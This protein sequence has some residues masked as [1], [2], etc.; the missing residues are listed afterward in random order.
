MICAEQVVEMQ[1]AAYNN[2]DYDAFASYYHK[3]I[4]S[5]DL[6]SNTASREMSGE[7]FFSYYRNK[8][9]MDFM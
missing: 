4:T 6:Q 5:V 1:L 8:L 3:D 2:R 9:F 7:G